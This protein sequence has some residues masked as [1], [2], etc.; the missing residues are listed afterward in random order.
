MS[1]NKPTKKAPTLTKMQKWYP[2][3]L[4]IAGSIGLLSAF[5]LT[6]DKLRVLQNPDYVPSCNVNPVIACGSV[7]N[8]DQ[9]SAFGIPNPWLGIFGF[10]AVVVVGVSLLAGMRVVKYW[11]WRLFSL[12]TI[13]GVAFVHWLMYQSIYNIG[14]L[15]PYCMVVW[16]VTIAIFWYTLLWTHR[17]GYLPTPRNWGKVLDFAN[18]NH[19]GILISWYLVIV[20]LILNR[21]W[22]FFGF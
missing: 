11:Y 19:L 8:T 17:E 16:V 9:A 4:T 22:Y 3:L 2:W 1:A 15:C 21:F 10:A 18:R 6:Y 20:G 12:G 14:A 5:V 7:I 13:F